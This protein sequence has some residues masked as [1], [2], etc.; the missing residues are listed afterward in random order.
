MIPKYNF[1]KVLT[2][3]LH[4]GEGARGFQRILRRK[5]NNNRNK[6]KSTSTTKNNSVVCHVG[7]WIRKAK[8]TKTENS[9][10]YNLAYQLVFFRTKKEGLYKASWY[11]PDA[12]NFKMRKILFFVIQYRIIQGR[13]VYLSWVHTA[14]TINRGILGP[15]PP[16]R[17]FLFPNGSE[18]LYLTFS[19]EQLPKWNG[20]TSSI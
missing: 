1:A 13:S 3:R 20:N 14:G 5:E 10:Q 11:G 15:F 7:N 18:M 19:K 12:S 2:W 16:S 4:K 17:K 9:L 6:S 8:T